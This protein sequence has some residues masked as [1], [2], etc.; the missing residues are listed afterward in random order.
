L[1]WRN[2]LGQRRRPGS[3]AGSCP[4]HSLQ[5]KVGIPHGAVLSC[6]PSLYGRQRA[7]STRESNIAEVSTRTSW[8]TP[9]PPR[10]FPT[11]PACPMGPPHSDSPLRGQGAHKTSPLLQLSSHV[12]CVRMSNK[13][14]CLTAPR[15]QDTVR[16]AWR[17]SRTPLRIRFLEAAESKRDFTHA[18]AAWQGININT[19][20]YY[21]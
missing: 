13:N 2:C 6:R 3:F 16:S 10:H 19:P 1:W 9:R 21:E 4:H 5:T 14:M 20:T 11:P 7:R 12:L 8:T 17:V 18:H 15:R